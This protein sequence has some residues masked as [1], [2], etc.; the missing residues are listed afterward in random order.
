MT[1]PTSA[2]PLNLVTGISFFLQQELWYEE[3][4][5]FAQTVLDGNYLGDMNRRRLHDHAHQRCCT[6][7]T[8]WA[9]TAFPPT[10]RPA[11]T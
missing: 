7:T 1:V 11:T 3:M 4:A 10:P 8:P 5:S 2:S 6:T 9:P